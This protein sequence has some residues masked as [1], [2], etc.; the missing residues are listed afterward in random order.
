M[1]NAVSVLYFQHA[2]QIQH[3]WMR[4]IEWSVTSCDAMH[5][6]RFT[7]TTRR[8]HRSAMEVW[9]ACHASCDELAVHVKCWMQNRSPGTQHQALVLLASYCG[10]SA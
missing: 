2:L 3:T 1:R 10:S 9:L 5:A 7:N 8:L 6:S 4:A